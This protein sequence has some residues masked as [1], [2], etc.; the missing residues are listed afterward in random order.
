MGMF[1]PF[2]RVE[3]DV[4]LDVPHANGSSTDALLIIGAD[5][6]SA[7]EMA[8]QVAPNDQSSPCALCVAPK[9]KFND[10]ERCRTHSREK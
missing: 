6:A 2:A 3:V 7:A 8:S 4:E 10:P 1:E 5:V 9:S